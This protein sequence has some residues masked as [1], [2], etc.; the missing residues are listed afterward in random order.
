MKLEHSRDYYLDLIKYHMYR[1]CKNQSGLAR[2]MGVSSAA[3][4]QWLNKDP[5]RL[6]MVLPFICDEFFTERQCARAIAGL[7]SLTEVSNEAKPEPD[8]V[9]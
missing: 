2:K 4:W 1:T 5:S 6:Y 7:V 8:V 3:I 9:E